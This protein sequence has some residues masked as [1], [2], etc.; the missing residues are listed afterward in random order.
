MKTTLIIALILS[1]YLLKSQDFIS[2]DYGE[3]RAEGT[4]GYVYILKLSQNN[5]FEFIID[6]RFDCT[7][8]YAAYGKG[9]FEIDQ[10]SIIFVF[11]S[12]PTLLSTYTLDSVE[13]MD[14]VVDLQFQVTNKEQEARTD[15]NLSWGMPIVKKTRILSKFFDQKFDNHTTLKFPKNEKIHFIRIE[16]SGYYDGEIN[17]SQIGT[18]D[19][20]IKVELRPK[21]SV[22]SCVYIS[23]LKMKLGILSD[24]KIILG[25]GIHLEKRT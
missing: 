4:M 12:I 22:E 10:D 20:S 2:L 1:A 15:L 14:Y 5:R 8:R 24:K 19:Y 17:L 23:N 6:S 11:D 7:P 18:K 3:Y 21:P 25:E 16:K 13:N 9:Q